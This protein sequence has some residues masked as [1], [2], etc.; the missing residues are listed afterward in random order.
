VPASAI[1]ADDEGATIVKVVDDKNSHTTGRC[2][3]A[4]GSPKW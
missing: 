2:K 4:T 3:S 1:L